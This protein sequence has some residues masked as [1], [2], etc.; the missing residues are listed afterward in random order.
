M[1]ATRAARA[2]ASRMSLGAKFNETRRGAVRCM[3]TL[4]SLLCT[5]Y[6]V[7]KNYTTCTEYFLAPRV[8][9]THA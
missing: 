8:Q 7:M 1:V 6:T 4:Y 2:A 5:V 3:C 9:R